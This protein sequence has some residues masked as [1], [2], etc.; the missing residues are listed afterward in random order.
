MEVVGAGVQE[1]LMESED[2]AWADTH[3][4][5]AKANGNMTVCWID[6]KKISETLHIIIISTDYILE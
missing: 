6:G 2:I 3:D 1:T 5:A 4:G